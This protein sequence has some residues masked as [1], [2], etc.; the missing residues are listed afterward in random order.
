MARDLR[1]TWLRHWHSVIDEAIGQDA[2]FDFEAAYN[3]PYG[4]F[5]MH[6][7]TWDLPDESLLRC[8][9]VLP[10]GA[11]ICKR[12]IEMR[13]RYRANESRISEQGALELF[14]R[15]LNDFARFV[16]NEDLKKP[17]RVVRGTSAEIRE[18]MRRADR[19]A[20]LFE[21]IDWNF[22]SEVAE[23]GSFLRETLYRLANSYD[24]ADYVDWPLFPDPQSVDPHRSFALLALCDAYSPLL[25]ADGPVLFVATDRVATC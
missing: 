17:I 1:R 8:F 24:V 25:D 5:R 18:G 19:V 2:A 22:D 13:S 23:A 4:D 6:F 9:Q 15:G 12:A 10:R 14:R 21:D 7:V 11:E 3:D 20:I 16:E